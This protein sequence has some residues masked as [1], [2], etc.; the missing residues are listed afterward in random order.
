[1]VS[2][3]PIKNYNNPTKPKDPGSFM[4]RAEEAGIKVV[5]GYKTEKNQLSQ[6]LRTWFGAQN[7][8]K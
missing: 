2:Y 6:T 7:N 5:F 8:K 4:K 1:L 3:Q